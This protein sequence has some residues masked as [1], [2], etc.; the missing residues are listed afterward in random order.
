MAIDVKICGIKDM[1]ALDAAIA[2]DARW[3]GLVLAPK[4]PR[5]V[6]L[7]QAAALAARARGRIET[8][9]LLVD[10]DDAAL[11]AVQARLAPDWIQLHGGESPQRT[12]FARRFARSGVI[13]ALPIASGEDFAAAAVYAP[14]ADM[15]LFDAKAPPGAD[16]T[17]G[18]GAAF[19]W[20]LL[21][22]RAIPRPWMLAGG[23][24]PEN[25]AEAIALSQARAVDVSSGVEEAPGL[26][27]ANRI[28]AF[29][30]AARAAA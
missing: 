22:G 10:P 2:A 15:L 13:K 6:S 17:G 7:E 1:A 23:L 18:H 29:A 5:F 12:A 26:K 9:A 14:V 30:R 11:E 28:A 25:V 24:T 3:A 16:R 21:A 20:R 8:V 4:S 27:N 19:D